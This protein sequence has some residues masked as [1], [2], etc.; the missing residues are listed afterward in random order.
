[1]SRSSAS[2]R[3]ARRG[4]PRRRGAAATWAARLSP[5]NWTSMTSGGRE[6]QRVRAAPMPVGHDRDERAAAVRRARRG[7]RPRPSRRDP[8]QVDRDDEQ[9]AGAAGDGLL[10]GLAQPGVQAMP[11]LAHRPR[12]GVE[13]ECPDL[14]VGVTTSVSAMA[15]TA[16]TT[17]GWSPR[18]GGSRGRAAPRRRG[19]RPSRDLAPSSVPTGMTATTRRFGRARGR[20]VSGRGAGPRRPSRAR[21]ASPPM[22]VSVTWTRR[23]VAATSSASAASTS[24]MTRS[25]ATSAYSRATPSALDSWPSEASI[26]SAG[27]LSALPPMMPLTAMTGTPRARAAA[28]AS[29]MPGHGQDRPDRHDRVRRRDDDRRRRR[30]WPRAPP[31]SPGPPRCPEADLVDVG[32]LVLVDEVLLELQPA[33]VGPDLGA[34]RV[35]AHRQD[36]RRVAQALAQAQRDRRR[37]HPGAEPI[38]PPQ[39]R[40]QVAVPE[41]EPGSS[42][43]S[44]ASP[45]ITA[46]VSS[47]SPQPRSSSSR[48]ASV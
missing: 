6:Q 14:V 15:G 9:R 7:R 38:R 4:S 27:P 23:P 11:A 48:P 8:R 13:G 41:P 16:T 19:P 26:R 31:P 37:A 30:R 45:S 32:R 21:P 10:A 34:D 35:V 40:R 1:M 12:A 29:R 2:G 36:R 33:L 25:V 17:P 44:A 5:P 46:Q 43:I 20:P 42:P 3:R 28:I 47:R 18:R 24:S 39:V 22:I